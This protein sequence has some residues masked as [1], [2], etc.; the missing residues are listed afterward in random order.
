MGEGVE[1]PWASYIPLTSPQIACAQLHSLP[2]MRD[3][4]IQLSLWWDGACVGVGLKPWA[5]SVSM[6]TAAH[7]CIMRL[8][9]H[10]SPAFATKHCFSSNSAL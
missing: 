9:F 7:F 3:A 8:L 10:E 5:P 2:N 1:D 4:L 6:S